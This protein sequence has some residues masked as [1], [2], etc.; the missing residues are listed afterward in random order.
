MLPN[1]SFKKIFLSIS[2][3]GFL[4]ISSVYGQETYHYEFKISG[5]NSL[6]TAKPITT[7]MRVHFNTDEESN[8]YLP[9]YNILTNGYDFTASRLV[10]ESDLN[11]FLSLHGYSLLE[12]EYEV[13]SETD[14]K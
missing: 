8:A 11:E 12:F 5:V 9:N 14:K 3:F 4:L 2:V 1:L 7:L 10:T 13:I 6:A